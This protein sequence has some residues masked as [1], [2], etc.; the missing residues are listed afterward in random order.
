MRSGPSEP[1]FS[2]VYP[3]AVARLILA[4]ALAAALVLLGWLLHID[5]L[6]RL[7]PGLTSMNPL[8][9][10]SFACACA[11][12]W[13]LRNGPLDGRRRLC[14]G[15]L[16]SVALL[17]GLTKLFDLAAGTSL[18][19]DDL[20][21]RSQLDSGQ[22]FPSRIAP[23]AA[24]CLSLLGAGILGFDRSAW[25]SLLHPQRLML[26]VFA[27]S[28][29]AL[30]GYAYDSSGFYKYAAFIPMALHSAV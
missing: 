9:A 15:L 28:G 16:G 12:L 26:P 25:P 22:K 19:P 30:V 13:L 7:A 23:N 2:P 6:K 24:L 27:L 1:A 5:R 17:A 10:L 21:F 11:A 8:T 4:T 14:A 18:C 20:L 3:A 29:A